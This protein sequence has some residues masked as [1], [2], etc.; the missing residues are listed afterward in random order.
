MKVLFYRNGQVVVEEAPRPKPGSGEVLVQNIYS[1]ISPGSESFAVSESTLSAKASKTENILKIV[2]S[3]KEKGVAQTVNRM[4]NAVSSQAPLGYSSA[5]RVIEAGSRATNF[6]PGDL[7]AC[8]GMEKAVHGELVC[9]PINLVAKLPANFEDLKQ[10]SFGAIG[11]IAMNSVRKLNPQIGDLVV[12]Y[13]AGLIGLVTV[14]VLKQSGARILVVEPNSDRAELAKKMGAEMVTNEINDAFVSRVMSLSSQRGADAA[15]FAAASDSPDALSEAAKVIRSGGKLVVLGKVPVSLNYDLAFKKDINLLMARSYGPGRYD[16][17]YEEAGQDYPAEYVRWTEK[18]NLEEFLELLKNKHIDLSP[19][20]SREI[21]LDSAPALYEE[22]KSKHA[23]LGAV[24]RYDSSE[25]KESL[26]E[27]IIQNTFFQTKTGVVRVGVIGV[28][29]YA[30]GTLLPIL[31]ELPEYEIRALCARKS[32]SL[33]R[34][35]KQYRAAY[36]CTDYRDILKDPEIDLVFILTPNNT[37]AQM[38]KECLSAGKACFVEKPLCINL[39]EQSDLERTLGTNHLPVVVGF[40]RRCAPLAEILRTELNKLSGP[41]FIDYTVNAGFMD[42]SHWM[43]NPEVGGGRWVSEGCHFVDFGR[44]LTGQEIIKWETDIISPNGQSVMSKDNYL[45]RLTFSDGSRMNINYV[46]LGAKTY[47]KENIHIFRSGSVMEMTD[48]QNLSVFSANKK[49]RY[50]L[51]TIDKGHVRELGEI[52][53]LLRGRPSLI[54]P[55]SDSLRSNRVTLEIIQ[56]K[57]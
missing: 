4:F 49:M 18:R 3:L 24:I 54:P 31:N 37:H 44:F 30:K 52:S 55:I 33:P 19:L 1:A 48:F 57:Q 21:S 45:V 56:N 26:K 40:N 15:I 7:V 2:N 34:L 11:C 32:L 20:I 10:A 35:M 41:I 43:Q 23:I 29:D 17:L 9:V 51:R 14:S 16:P 28:G 22:L 5:G 12:V 25:N 53:K 13:G 27:T 47:P 42:P 38:I 36:A 46:S 8:M 39:A 50:N 6:Q